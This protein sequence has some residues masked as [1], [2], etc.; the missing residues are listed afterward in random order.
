MTDHNETTVEAVQADIERIVERVAEH[1]YFN[2]AEW[3]AD[4][5]AALAAI[6]EPATVGGVTRA[7]MVRVVNKAV[8]NPS[9]A[10]HITNAILAL[11]PPAPST[12]GMVEDAVA[13]LTRLVA[14]ETQA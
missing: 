5:R 7:E 12:V 9:L 6:P 13:V 11:F 10:E 8:G 1:G 14:N 4:I 3:R 2:D